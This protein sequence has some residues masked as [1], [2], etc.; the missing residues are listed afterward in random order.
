MPSRYLADGHSQ[1]LLI[2]AGIQVLDLVDLCLRLAAL[3]KG[4]V[5]LLPQE[6]AAADEGGGVLELP[7]HHR[8]P[9][10]QAEGKVTVAPNPLHSAGVLTTLLAWHRG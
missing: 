10:V 1:E 4:G 3:G 7:P 5:P 9:L 8:G 2:D 6:L